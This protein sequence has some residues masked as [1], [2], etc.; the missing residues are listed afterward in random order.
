METSSLSAL[1]L[2]GLFSP[3]YVMLS[4]CGTATAFTNNTVSLPLIVLVKRR[5]ARG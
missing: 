4:A 5:I 1:K 2:L 3:V